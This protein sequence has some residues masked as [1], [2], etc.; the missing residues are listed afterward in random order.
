MPSRFRLNA[1]ASTRI[2]RILWRLGAFAA[3]W[4]LV[5][6]VAETVLQPLFAA[7]SRGVGEPVP[8]YPFAMLAGCIGGTYASLR[9]VFIAPWSLVGCDAGAWRARAWRDGLVVGTMA[10]LAVSSVLWATGALRVAAVSSPADVHVV[11]S[12]GA[13]AL[14]VLVILAPSALWEELAFRGV[15]QGAVQ[16]ATDSPFAARLAS[17]LLFGGVHL[18]NPGANVQTTGTVMLA[19]WCLALLR[20]QRGLPAAWMAHLAWNWIMAAVLH[21]PVSGLPFSTPGYRA[22]AAGPTWFSGGS[23]GPEG[24]IVAAFILAGAAWYWRS[25]PSPDALGSPSHTIP[26]ARS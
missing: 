19:G 3:G 20:E 24:S 11:D 4:V 2:G 1:S 12:W 6:G 10:I 7:I 14:R 13:T 21:V 18:T 5:Q 9:L 8:F 15:L 25:R 16:E 26:L 22:H 17:S 23:W